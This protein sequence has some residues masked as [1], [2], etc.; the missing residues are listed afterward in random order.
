MNGRMSSR[1]CLFGWSVQV[2][3]APVLPVTACGIF[4][5]FH[6]DWSE[7]TDVITL[8]LYWDGTADTE[9]IQLSLAVQPQ[10]RWLLLLIKTS[11]TYCTDWCQTAWHIFHGFFFPSLAAD[12]DWVE[13]GV[14]LRC[15]DPLSHTDPY[16]LALHYFINLNQHVYLPRSN[17]ITTLVKATH[18]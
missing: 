5:S 10:H 1:F 4:H 12:F 8:M 16:P 9:S 15:P 11:L 17:P 18:S 14:S 3:V 13:V 7:H 6:W 2:S